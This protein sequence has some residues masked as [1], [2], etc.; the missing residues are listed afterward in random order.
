MRNIPP[1]T[2]YDVTEEGSLTGVDTD[3]WVEAPLDPAFIS[4]VA[5]TDRTQFRLYFDHLDGFDDVS[6]AWYSSESIGNEPQL[7]VQYTDELP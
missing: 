7:I 5:T 6:A 1:S 4:D 2:D 3:N